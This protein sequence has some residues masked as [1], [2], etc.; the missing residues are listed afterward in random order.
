MNK[1]ILSNFQHFW[2]NTEITNLCNVRSLKMIFRLLLEPT[3]RD[4]NVKSN[5]MMD[6]CSSKSKKQIHLGCLLF[7]L[8]PHEAPSP[9]IWLVARN[10]FNIIYTSK[11]RE[12]SSSCETFSSYYSSSTLQNQLFLFYIEISW[13]TTLFVRTKVVQNYKEKT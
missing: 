13:H 6:S 7:N 11:Y 9:Q 12:Y 3:V 10:F 1:K 4:L 5:F 8:S 2:C